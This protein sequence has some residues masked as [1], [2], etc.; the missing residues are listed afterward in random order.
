MS[1]IDIIRRF[2][3]LKALFSR[4]VSFPPSPLFSSTHLHDFVKVLSRRVEQA[5][6][7]AFRFF[8]SPFVRLFSNKAGPNFRFCFW[9]GSRSFWRIEIV[10]RLRKIENKRPFGNT[11]KYDG[12]ARKLGNN[13]HLQTS[14]PQRLDDIPQNHDVSIKTTRE[15]HLSSFYPK[16][17]LRAN[18]NGLTLPVK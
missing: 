1:I 7:A 17:L 3:R 2:S 8:F 12:K 9:T 10:L 11:V 4:F 5:W 6:D 16:V 18:V 13:G 14:R 15:H